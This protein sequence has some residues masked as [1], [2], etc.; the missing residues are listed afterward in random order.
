MAGLTS[1]QPCAS[2]SLRFHAAPGSELTLKLD[3]LGTVPAGD[4]IVVSDW[5]DTKDKLV[6]LDLDKSTGVLVNFLSIP[7]FLLVVS[8]AAA[9]FVNR[10]RHHAVN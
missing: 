2:N 3:G 8:G 5:F 9:F 10:I 7:G 6:G 1:T 4:L